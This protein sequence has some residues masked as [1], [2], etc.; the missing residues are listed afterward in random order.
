M[1]VQNDAMLIKELRGNRCHC[2]NRKSPHRTF[3]R[4]CFYRLKPP[5]RQALYQRIGEGYGEAY[6]A[7]VEYLKTEFAGDERENDFVPRK[8]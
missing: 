6:A 2:G 1:S 7:A 8:R 5:M 3:C 4:P